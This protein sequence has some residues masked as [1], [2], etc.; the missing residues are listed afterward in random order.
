[1]T[2]AFLATMGGFYLN[3]QAPL[4]QLELP[5]SPLTIQAGGVI[6]SH[7]FE[8]LLDHNPEAIPDI[9]IE[10]NSRL[11]KLLLW[12]Q[13]MWFWVTILARLVQCLPLSLLE[14]LTFAHATCTLLTSALWWPKPMGVDDT[15]SISGGEIPVGKMVIAG[16]TFITRPKFALPQFE[17]FEPESFKGG[18]SNW[19]TYHAF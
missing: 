10:D 5:Q 3:C 18:Q 11:A 12:W 15:F 4:T 8:L 9:S 14:V 2:H 6:T 13:V 16:T 1:M 19:Y 17:V 7:G